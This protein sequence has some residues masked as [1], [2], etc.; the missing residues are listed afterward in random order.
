MEII[1]VDTGGTFTDFIFKSGANWSV[2]KRESTPDNPAR[3]VIE[4]LED[5]GGNVFERVVHG[6]TVATNAVLERKGVSTGF[7]TNSGFEDLLFIG[8]QQRENIYDLFSFRRRPVVPRELCFG[9]PG[10]IDSL[11]NEIEPFDAR[12]ARKAA[13]KLLANGVESVAVCFLFSY[14]NPRHELIMRD[15][16]LDHGLHVS[17]SHC[18]LAEFR[19]FERSSTTAINAYVS[20]RMSGYLKKLQD[21]PNVGR[22]RIMQSNGGSISA[23]TAM[24]ESVRTILSGPA[25][26]VVGAFEIGK[27]A[28][29]DRLI[30]F[31]MGG[32]STDVSLI[33][34]E[35]PLSLENSLDGH[36]L[37]VPMLDIHTVG[38]GGGS[39]AEIDEGG[40]LRVGPESAGADPGPVCYGKGKRITVTDANLFLGRLIADH[41]LGGKKNLHVDRL[42]DS[43]SDLVSKTGLGIERLA[44]GIV[45]VANANMERAIR[46]I[47]VERGFDPREFTLFSFGGAG[48]LH[49]AYL[50]RLLS[51]PRVMIPQNPGIL[52]AAGMCM[53]DVVRD[54]SRTV[55]LSGG[56]TSFTELE[57]LFSGIAD[58]AREEMHGEGFPKDSLRLE[59]FIDMRYK[60]QSYEIIV[61]FDPDYE[62]AF[63]S[64]HERKYGYCSPG[65]PKEIVNLRLRA[66]GVPEK[67]PFRAREDPIEKI[68]QEARLGKQDTIFEGRR[69][70]TGILARDKLL[71]G[72]F[73]KGPAIVVEYTSTIAV[74]PFAEAETDAFGNLI[75]HITG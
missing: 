57:G 27:A 22:L 46:V 14:L 44:E 3:A 9:I 38:A 60:G 35:L 1:G 40:S 47:S 52:S 19:E 25:G 62:N 2:L 36:P 8:R 58:T 28:G 16:L 30:T 75:L 54:Y 39:I 34:G 32:T 72:N 64:L 17:V 21:S 66:R 5:I 26:G 23:S 41:F 71:P 45:D 70:S 65:A 74:P 50:A 63:A 69:V 7:I 49:C 18:I 53:A 15:I 37:K 68:P 33:N 51:I 20:P 24:R 56:D 42:R 67:P 55:M 59:K 61:P 12:A 6:S 11:G 31:D 13:E 48:G 10:R 43:F 73:F 29:F 4:G